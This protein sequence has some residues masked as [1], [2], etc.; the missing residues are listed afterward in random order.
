[1]K[2]KKWNRKRI[3]KIIGKSILVLFILFVVLVLVIRTPWAQ[4]RIVSEITDY[5]SGKT[6]TKVEV[7][8]V[9]ITFS[10]NIMAQGIYLEDKQGDTLLYSQELQLDLPIYPLLVKN[11]LSIDDVEA[12]RLVANISRN[13]DPESFNFAFL[14]DAF[15]SPDT[16]STSEPMSISL[17]DFQLNDWKVRYHD[18]Y[19]GTKINVSIGELDI[20]VTEFDLEEMIFGVDDFVLKNSQISYEQTHSTPTSDDTSTSTPPK[21]S[22]D[23]IQLEEVTMVYNSEPDGIRTK[24][25][26]SEFDLTELAVDVS[27]NSYKTDEIALKNSNIKLHLEQTTDTIKSPEQT[28]SFQWPQLELQSNQLSLESNTI[29]FS[30]NAAK[31]TDTI[32]NPDAFTISQLTFKSSDFRYRPANVKLD[33]EAF[34]FRESSGIALQQLDFG[35]S[36]SDTGAKISDLNLRLNNS[37]LNA[38]VDIRYASLDAAFNNPENSS[39]QLVVS[40]LNLEPSDAQLFSPE[41][42]KNSYLDSLATNPITGYLRANGSLKKVDDLESELQWGPSTTLNL[43]GTFSNITQR[44]AFTYNMGNLDIKSTKENLQKFI[45][46]DSL[47]FKVPETIRLAGSLQGDLESMQTK[48]ILTIPEG[49]VNLDALADFGNQKRFEGMI[50]TDSLQ[51]GSLLKNNQLGAVSVQLKGSG[52]GNELAD[53]DARLEGTVGLLQFKEY[54]Y[55]DININGELAS[56]TGNISLSLKDENLN[57][58][59]KTLVDFTSN[60]NNISFTSNIIGADLRKLGFT[61]NDIKI[62]GDLEGSYQGNSNKY[63]VEAS[64]KNGI[65]VADNKQY[66]ITPILINAR[67]EDS[68]TDATVK[69]GFLNGGLHSNASLNRINTALKKQVENYFSTDSTLS[70][71]LDDVEAQLDLAL[72]PTPII[73]KVFF[74][75]FEDVDSVNIDAKF[76]ARTKQIAGKVSVPKF[77]YAGSTVDSLEVNLQGDSTNLNFYAGLKNFKL[78][79]VHLKKTYIEGNLQNKELV[80]DFNS[81]NDTTQIMH[82]SSELVFKK[83]T[84][85]LHIS[86]ENLLLN[87]KPW[88]IPDDNK[89]VMA[90]SYT[91]FTNLKLSRNGQKL[92]VSTAVPEMDSVHIGIIFENFQLQTFLSLLNP[93]QALAKGTV[94]G[95]FVVLNPYSASGLVSKMDITDFQFMQTPLGS[96]SL[97]ASSKSLSDYD[98]DLVVKG[99]GADLSLTGNYVAQQQ[100]ADLNMDLDIQKF[101]TRIVQGFL[102]EQI[103][104]ASGYISGSM[105]V[106]G[107]TSNPT[108]SGRLSFN[109]VGV[110]LSAFKTKLGVSGQTLSLNEE[111]IVFDDFSINDTGSGTLVL[112]GAI[113]T[114]E[115]LNPGFD[116][117]IRADKFT[118]LD[119]K[120]GD[121]ELVYGK[122]IVDTDLEVTGNLELPVINGKINIG[123]ATDLT[124]LVPK[125]QYE[126]QEREGVVIFVNRKNPDAILTRNTGE[127]GNSVFAGMDINTTLEI[128]DKA[129]F[130]VVLDERTGD[131]LQASGNATL[132]LSLNRNDNIGLSGRLELN[133]GFY[134]T[135]LYNLVN[136]KFTINDGSTVVWSGDPYNATLDVTATYEVETS[137]TPLM[138]SISYG[139]D[140][141][142]SGQYQRPATFLVYLMVGGEIM[143]PEISFSLDMPESAQGSYG[144]GV[145]GRIQQLN[146][147]ES[148]LNKQV[149][150]LLALNRFFP[151]SGSDGSSGGAVALARDNVNKALSGELN[152]LSNKIMGNT[153][154]ELDFD[155]DSFQENQGNGY[156]NRTQLNINARKKLFDDRFIV[157]AG[158]AVDVEGRASSSDTSTPLIGNVTLE[159]LLSEEGTYRLKGFRRQEYQNIIDGQLIVTGLAFIFN[160]EFNKFSQLFSPIKA[161]A[162]EE[163]PLAKD[164]DKKKQ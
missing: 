20:E 163:E 26:L 90:D 7:Q 12:T 40:Q 53:I 43:K 147:Q 119:S 34:S 48:A 81:V 46:T 78:D 65:A 128:S 79:P 86:P 146:E 102:K 98:F 36:I 56:G 100:G 55:K 153:G 115:L 32:F 108:Y 3:L 152:S 2:N 135:S 5:V 28:T 35:A 54:N 101:E 134:R 19:L 18:A 123:N 157:T 67:V 50:S 68:I 42:Q 127:T 110:T 143:S 117:I 145:Y 120:K 77:T 136:R 104:D 164:A 17:G 97:N 11:E 88:E 72:V 118:V 122:A 142:I 22:I 27:K 75:G 154:L 38:N 66:Q 158:S 131:M 96:L 52:S 23:G 83:D 112:D 155:L 141:G 148:E 13:T 84:L 76:N 116:L 159:Y 25:L 16:T 73:S 113:L 107:T 126:I 63:A 10:G 150:S 9:F 4:N 15:A 114:E 160:R 57:L 61:K 89:I 44:E 92:E 144:G 91:E 138:S 99:E 130:K 24:A 124:Y 64:I 74:D 149:F 51:L 69:S 70:K 151:T 58:T 31:Q 45:S 59:A 49:R 103:S 106:G 37:S 105:Q 39:L 87:K 139:Q 129:V 29:N 132:N 47:S 94:Q 162:K 62:A 93:E 140:T 71:S 14:I 125:S 85:S 121:N 156:Q 133:S 161:K 82:V 111:E 109:E 80:L 95:N 6:N 41:L 1:M 8:K 60:S 33:L 21:I 30:R 137:P